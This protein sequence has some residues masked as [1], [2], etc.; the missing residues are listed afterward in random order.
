MAATTLHLHQMSSIDLH[1]LLPSKDDDTE[2]HKNMGIL[3]ARTLKKHVPYFSK[4]GQGVGRHIRFQ[5][6][7]KLW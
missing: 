2:I 3:M 4:F 1:M 7:K 6:G 5:P